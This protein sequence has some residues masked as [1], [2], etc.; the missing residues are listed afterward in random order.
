MEDHVRVREQAP[1]AG[2][3]YMTSAFFVA[4]KLTCSAAMLLFE[5]THHPDILT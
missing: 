5:V 2:T 4:L 1:R 3:K